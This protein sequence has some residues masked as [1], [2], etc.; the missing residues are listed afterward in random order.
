MIKGG[1]K[2][3]SKKTFKLTAIALS[4]FSTMSILGGCSSKPAGSQ[5][6]GSSDQKQGKV[7]VTLW[8]RVFEDW[9]KAWSEKVVEDFNKSQ[10]KVEI[11]QKFIPGDAWDQSMKSAQAAGE[12][13]DIYLMNYG[14]IAFAA[15]DGLIE[16]LDDLIPKTA[17]DDLYPNVSQFVGYK[18]KHYAYPQLLEPSTVLYYRKDLFKAAGLDPEKPPVTWDELVEDGKKLTKGDVFGLGVA[19]VAPDMGWATWG[20]QQQAAGHFAVTD[21]WSKATVT[22]NGYKDLLTF[23]KK[24]YDNKI[25]PEQALSGYADIKAFGEG[26]LA[27]VFCGSW[28]IG[29]LKTTYPD[30]IPNLGIAVAPTKDGNQDKVTSTV[31][32]WT[33]VVDAKSKHKKEAADYIT[34]LLGSDPSR[35]VEFFK[36][37]GWSKYSPRKS[38]DTAINNDAEAKNDMWRKTIAEKIVPKSV[39]VPIYAWDISMSVANAIDKVV[40]NNTKVEDA[41]KEAEQ[42]INDYIKNN[43]YAGTNPLLAK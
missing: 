12:A 4:L 25:V 6:S 23:Y 34:W 9:N 11:Q 39:A 36:T 38:V 27:M 5:N 3:F 1:I 33:Y 32:G 20:W 26:K 35:S 2:L 22:D 24:L 29:Q 40:T 21:D 41:L 8:N 17:W 30:I 14:G 19:A 15:K 7:V 13:P 16:P 37:S 43:N 28:G 10:D 18:G 31:G 42:E